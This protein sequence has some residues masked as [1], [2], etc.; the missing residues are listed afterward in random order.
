MCAG[1]VIVNKVTLQQTAK[2]PLTED[3]NMVQALATNR[4]DQPFRVSILPGTPGCDDNFF[5][6]QR[7]E[8]TTK[9]VAVDRVTITDQVMLGVTIRK[10]FHNLLS[11]PF[12]GRMFRDAEMKNSSP[13]MLDHQE[14]EQHSQ[15][16]CRHGKK[17]GRHDLLQVILQE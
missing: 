17:I 13:L 15:A 7:L 12:R 4:S 14:H 9:L 1:A 16:D 2:M 8:A 10:G 11:S 3:H 6:A 5:H